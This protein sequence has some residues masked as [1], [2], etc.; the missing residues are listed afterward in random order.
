MIIN[1]PRI[2]VIIAECPPPKKKCG[3][4]LRNSL[5]S[6]SMPAISGGTSLGRRRLSAGGELGGARSVTHFS[7]VSAECVWHQKC[8]CRNFSISARTFAGVAV[9]A[10]QLRNSFRHIQY[11]PRRGRCNRSKC[12][13]RNSILRPKFNAVSRTARRISSPLLFVKFGAI[14]FL[15]RRADCFFNP[16][17][18]QIRMLVKCSRG[19]QH[20]REET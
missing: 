5:H 3:G 1:R 13:S 17:A 12:I 19:E 18:R 16:A 9:S 4:K 14:H 2:F 10:Q 15:L 11:L 7:F 20:C 6:K 8:R